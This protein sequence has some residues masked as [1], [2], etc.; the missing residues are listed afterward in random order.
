M[1]GRVYD[2]SI[3]RF[4]SADPFVQAP[5]N[6]QSLNRYS[7]VFNNPLSFADPSGFQTAAD[8]GGS[9][10]GGGGGTWVSF[11]GI[12]FSQREPHP[13]F[14][15]QRAFGGM[16]FPTAQCTLTRTQNCYAFNYGN[17]REIIRPYNPPPGRATDEMRRLP[18]PV[19][20]VVPAS[21]A[22]QMTTASADGGNSIGGY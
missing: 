13:D 8:G 11:I 6:S 12:V 17:P 2:P 21:G 20:N 22:D 1:N 16:H 14:R 19:Q 10:N 15:D 4:M 7:Y 18:V 9:Y 3:G 5:L